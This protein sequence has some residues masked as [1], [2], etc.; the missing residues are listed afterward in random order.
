VSRGSSAA[1]AD[2][3][4]PT[5]GVLV[6]ADIALAPGTAGQRPNFGGVWLPL[7]DVSET[8]DAYVVEIE[9][10]GVKRDDVDIELDGSELAVTGEFKERERKGLFRHH[11]R[12]LGRFEF[13]MTLPRNVDPDHVEAGLD[14]GVL[15][16]RIP[17]TDTAK[18]RRVEITRR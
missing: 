9:L 2:A 4:T 10:P 15:T 13:R 7:A 12:R 6:A 16:I 5:G 14:D 17:K 1:R 8:D 11:T 3:Q 18:P